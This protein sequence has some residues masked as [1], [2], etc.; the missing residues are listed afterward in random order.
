MG[1]LDAHEWDSQRS[2]LCARHE[3]KELLDKLRGKPVRGYLDRLTGRRASVFEEVCNW[4]TEQS[5]YQIE[6]IRGQPVPAAL[7]FLNLLKRD[8]NPL[9]ELML[10]HAN[11]K[12]S[13][14]HAPPNMDRDVRCSL[15][16][17]DSRLLSWADLPR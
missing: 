2:A 1:I 4:D 7:V 9:A 11:K 12:S 10:R 14:T 6:P 16:R 8:P 3:A 17:H 5:G 15:S 13:R